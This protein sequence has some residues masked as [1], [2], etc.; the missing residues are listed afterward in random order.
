MRYDD[1]NQGSTRKEVKFPDYRIPTTTADHSS[2]PVPGGCLDL[3]LLPLLL[4]MGAIRAS[5]VGEATLVSGQASQIVALMPCNPL[6]NSSVYALS[7][8]LVRKKMSYVYI[9]SSVGDRDVMIKDKRDD[10]KVPPL[11]FIPWLLCR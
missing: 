4:Y 5:F 11:G 3:L 8:T 6:L 7:N 10:D 9:G 2:F 1:A